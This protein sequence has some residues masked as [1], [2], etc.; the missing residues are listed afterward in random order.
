MKVLL[1]AV[2]AK[3]IHSNLAVYS[4]KEYAE[5][6]GKN[7]HEIKIK[8]YTINQYTEEIVS[9]IYE[10]QADIIGFSCYIWNIHQVM[11]V[12]NDLKS[13][14]TKKDIWVGG[15]EVSYNAVQVLSDN[16]NVNYVMCGEGEEILK[17][18]L[19]NYHE[20][21]LQSKSDD[22]ACGYF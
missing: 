3:Y 13:V 10:E 18:F 20:G 15:P 12:I 22:E 17:Q 2:N 21:K 5:K 7:E 11:Q 19:D 16:A 8:E 1:V 4:L 6:Y 9:D 14:C